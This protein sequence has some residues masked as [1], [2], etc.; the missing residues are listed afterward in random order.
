MA[1]NNSIQFLRGTSTARKASSQTLLAGQ[2]FYETDT[3]KLYVGTILF[4][5]GKIKTCYN[6]PNKRF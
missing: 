6:I 5:K 4:R 3:K 1:G 2:P